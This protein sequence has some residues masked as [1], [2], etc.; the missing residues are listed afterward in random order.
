MQVEF[1]EHYYQ[2]K[3]GLKLHYREYGSGEQ[4]IIC[5]PG[6]TRNCKDFHDI[7][8]H[9]RPKYRVICP[10]IRGRGQSQRDTNW[11]N[12]NI[13][14]YVPD[15][16]CL[17]EAAGITQAIFLGTSLGGLI[18]MTMAYQDSGRVRAI[19]LNDVGPE[20]DPKGVAR[21][22][23]YAGRNVHSSNWE[24]AVIQ[25]RDNYQTALTGM[26][27]EFWEG[28]V[29]RSYRENSEGIPVQDMDPKIGDAIRAQLKIAGVLKL[30]RNLRI[31]KQIRGVPLDT[32][33][34]LRAVSMPCLVIRGGSFGHSVGGNN[35]PY[36]IS[37][38]RPGSRHHPGPGPCT[39]AR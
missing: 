35:R 22:L 29:R 37:Q 39:P 10:D 24:D 21:I 32:G 26:P 1:E 34:A 33:E 18:S 15:I 6:L 4:A 13:T 12:Y 19:I 9:L 28:F 36:A 30:L 31:L 27:D 23:G 17:M 3:D 5:L 8:L 25:A 14:M 2:S 20:F 7:A 11:R 38:T 16:K